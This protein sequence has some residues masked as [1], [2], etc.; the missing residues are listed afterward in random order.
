MQ[1]APGKLCLILISMGFIQPVPP[2]LR[3]VLNV[4][5]I[6]VYANGKVNEIS[7]RSIFE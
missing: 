3:Y 6:C 4:Q 1:C 2:A 7:V 5:C